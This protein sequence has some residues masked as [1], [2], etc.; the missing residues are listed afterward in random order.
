MYIKVVRSVGPATRGG[1]GALAALLPPDPDMIGCQL[2]TSLHTDIP[3][4]LAGGLWRYVYSIVAN[5]ST[6]CAFPLYY[7]P[8]LCI[9]EIY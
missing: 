9:N 3:N 1:G 7:I 2:Q 5:H 6:L 8:I 4:G